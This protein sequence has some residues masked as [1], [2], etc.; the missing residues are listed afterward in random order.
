[1]TMYLTG[2]SIEQLFIT[3]NQELTKLHD[4]CLSNRLS[5][6]TDKTYFI[7]FSSKTHLN[8]PQLRIN[9]QI[10]NRTSKI[11]FLGVTYDE[12]MTFKYHIN[13]VTLKLARHIA[14]LH[15]IRDLMP[16]EVLK[17]FYYAHVYFYSPIAMPFGPLRILLILFHLNFSLRKLLE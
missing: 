14:L 8:L 15:Q 13:N 5:I 7:L 17:C 6:N 9:Q 1:M 10:I 11:K 16:Q 2:P 12:L 4:W 3:A